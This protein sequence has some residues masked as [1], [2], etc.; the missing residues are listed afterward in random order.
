MTQSELLNAAEELSL[1]FSVEH[2]SLRQGNMTQMTEIADRKATAIIAFETALMSASKRGLAETERAAITNV[3]SA[4]QQ[5][6]PY[7]KSVR[8]G[9][10]NIVTRLN[11]VSARGHVGAYAESGQQL[12]FSSG[13]QNYRKFV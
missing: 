10:S 4:A 8:N 1:V 9:V 2:D 3:V 6:I 5:N 7:L 12:A 13:V 11:G